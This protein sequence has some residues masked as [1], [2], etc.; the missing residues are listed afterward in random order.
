MRIGRSILHTV[1]SAAAVGGLVV[2]SGRTAVAQNA[3][4]KAAYERYCASCHGVDGKG[5]GPAAA[6]LK[7]PLPDLTQLAKN[8]NGEFPTMRVLHSV[9]GTLY[10]AGHG[11]RE[12][13]V[14]GEQLQAGAISGTTGAR[15]REVLQF[16]VSYV[17]ALQ[18]K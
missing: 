16:V 12:M 10:L 4:G 18:A 13:P 5:Q 7:N 2:A 1:L 8:N 14:W 6:S 3:A 9:D 17:G 11:S 15:K